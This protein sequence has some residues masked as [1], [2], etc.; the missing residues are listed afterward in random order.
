M[1]NLLILES[2]EED[3]VTNTY[4]RTLLGNVPT[5]GIRKAITEARELLTSLQGAVDGELLE[6]LDC[7]LHLR[8]VFLSATE[9]PQHVKHPERAR[10]PWK[11][12]ISILPALKTTHHLVQPV[13]EAF[14]AKLQRKLASTVPPRPIVQLSFDDAFVHL[15]RLFEDGL[16]V[17]GVLHYTDSQCLQVCDIPISSDYAHH[18]DSTSRILCP[19]SKPKSHSR[20]YMCGHFFRP[21]CLTPWRCWAP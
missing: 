13:D 15:S 21:S 10:L 5:N 7:R 9:C 12:G 20:L 19:A 14:S 11:E 17:I 8:D 6:A 16:G 3:F 1:P 4:N 2:Q 18:T